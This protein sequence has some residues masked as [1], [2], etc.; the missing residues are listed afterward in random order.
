MT[1]ELKTLKSLKTKE[2][3]LSRVIEEHLV[4]GAK[5]VAVLYVREVTP[6]IK[7]KG[8]KYF[9]RVVGYRDKIKVLDWQATPYEE[10][11]RSW[12]ERRSKEL[13]RELG[14]AVEALLLAVEGA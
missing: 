12:I 1:A 2:V 13:E 6:I 14:V 11:A 7:S 10:L 8:N 5:Y 9:E 3:R 4:L